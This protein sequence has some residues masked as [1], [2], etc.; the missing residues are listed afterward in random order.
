MEKYIKN[1]QQISFQDCDPF[2]QLHASKYIELFT[3]SAE[4]NLLSAFQ[5]NVFDHIQQ[6]GRGWMIDSYQMKLFQPVSANEKVWIE[7][8][9]IHFTDSTVVIELQMWNQELNTI[10]AAAWLNWK[11]YDVMSMKISKHE[12]ELKEM[13]EKIVVI[14]EDKMFEE[15]I[16]TITAQLDLA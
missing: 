11:Y 4:G 13:F 12:S 1:L 5:V 15:R 7:S 3:R 16:K 10:K 9:I 14:V 2:N 8:K 6:T